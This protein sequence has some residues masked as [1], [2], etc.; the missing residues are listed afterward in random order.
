MKKE[1]P[2]FQSLA[3]Q[4]FIT[5]LFKET[6][7]RVA[8]LPLS[9]ISFADTLPKLHAASFT[10]VLSFH[11]PTFYD[12]PT[13]GWSSR[14]AIVLSTD[15]HKWRYEARVTFSGTKS[16]RI[17]NNYSQR[18]NEYLHGYLKIRLPLIRSPSISHLRPQLE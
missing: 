3:P 17:T 5:T 4:Q 18:A 2:T 7:T 15:E 6:A 12:A 14:Q 13:F 9:L 10:R 11:S 1:W 8:R 16:V